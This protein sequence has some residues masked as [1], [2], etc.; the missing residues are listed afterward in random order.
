MNKLISICT[1]CFNEE[2]NVN[3]FHQR[4][5]AVFAALPQYR[6][7]MVVMDNASTDGTA[8]ALR[9]I[10]ARDPNVRVILNLRN[11]GIT[12][13][14]YYAIMKGA[15]DAVVVMSS[16]LQDPPELI[17]RFLEKWEA[18][19]KVAIAV[20][21]QSEESV[22]FSA[23]RRFYYYLVAGLADVPLVKNSTGFGLY[24][25]QV[26]EALRRWTIRIRIFAAWSARSVSSARRSPLCSQGEARFLQ[27]QPL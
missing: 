3:E 6:Y 4:V 14:G 27:A 16:D 1:S 19:Y 17:P 10:A 2:E 23:V 8:E 11:F 5:M 9:R 21:N 13:S 20:K 12:R 25:R 7:E 24:D 22:L 18:G 15:G 26:V